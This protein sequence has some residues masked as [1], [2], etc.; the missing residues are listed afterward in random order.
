MTTQHTNLQRY[1]ALMTVVAMIFM[2]IPMVAQAERLTSEGLVCEECG[3][4]VAHKSTCSKNIAP[5]QEYAP[6]ADGYAE[7]SG[8][9]E[10]GTITTDVLLTGDTYLTSI[11]EIP[12]G[13]KVTIDL[14]GYMLHGT[15]TTGVINN[16]GKLTIRDSRPTHGVHKFVPHEDGQWELDDENGTIEITGG[17]IT[18]GYNT[19]TAIGTGGGCIQQGSNHAEDVLTFQS[20]TIVGCYAARAGGAVYGGTINMSGGLVVG[21]Y[22]GQLG[23]A[24]SLSGKLNLS[25]GT[26]TNNHTSPDSEYNDSTKRPFYD[27]ASIIIGGSSAFTMSGGVLVGN[28][29]TV[30]YTL[31]TV[32][33]VMSGGQVLGK[34][35]LLTGA[36]F[37]L[38]N[39]ELNG[40]IYMKSG[41]CIV[42]DTMQ[43]YGG[44]E[45]KGGCICIEGGNF[46]MN[47]GNISVAQG[48]YG[49]AVYVSKG[50]CTIN[51]G[52][53]S[54]CESTYG[55]AVYVTGGEFAMYGGTLTQNT[56]DFGGAIY[57]TGGNVLMNGGSLEYNSANQNGGA[58]YVNAENNNPVI[59]ILSGSITHN[60]ASN[61][62]GAIS[63]NASDASS[64]TVNVGLESCRGQNH[65]EHADGACPTIAN[66]TSGVLGGAL[67]LHSET[68]NIN[69]NVQC[70]S[71][72][73]NKAT[74]NPGSNTLNQGGGHVVVWGGAISPGIM[75]GGG[76]Y[77][78]NRVDEHQIY[79]RFHANYAGGPTEPVLVEVTYGITMVFPV[80]TYIRAGYELSGWAT[81][82]DA[83]GLYIPSN[84]QYAI[85]E[86]ND[87]YLDFYA[88]W[89]ATTSYIVYI[90]DDATIQEDTANITISA[91]LSYFRA[92]SVL[93][94]TMLS[95]FTLTSQYQNHL[96]YHAETN[97]L[98]M[99]RDIESGDV[100]ASFQYNNTNAKTIRLTLDEGQSKYAGL[101]TDTITFVV[102]YEEED[103]GSDALFPAYALLLDNSASATDKYPLVFTRSLS[104]IQVGSTCT[105]PGY[106]QLTVLKV[107]SGFEDVNYNSTGSNPAPWSSDATKITSV[108]VLR[109]IKPLSI[110][111]WFANFQNC[112]YFDIGKI[113]TANAQSFAYTF[114]RAGY[115]TAT[116]TVEGLGRWNTNSLTN[117]VGMFFGS[118]VYAAVYELP[119]IENWNMSSVTS[120]EGMFASAGY[121][122]KNPVLNVTGWDVTSCTTINSMF[123]WFGQ[124]A[125]EGVTIIGLETWDV[126]NIKNMGQA[127]YAIGQQYKPEFIIDLSSWNPVATT[128]WSKIAEGTGGTIIL[129]DKFK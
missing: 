87:G 101:Y 118:G 125:T 58:I 90:P 123:A 99:F 82:P 62:G 73:N 80:D 10:G 15:G 28:V 18:G 69:V 61:H 83:S 96:T 84:G 35:R 55:G 77:D 116:F 6:L 3:Q 127:F 93:S 45:E 71:I 7:W 37:T 107:Y 5:I 113:N 121:R 43:I 20:G 89:N 129:P 67:C 88:V 122:A 31:D 1:I 53:I 81:A 95:D 56:A 30:D 25:G 102:G 59:N 9:V 42:S 66:N 4:N 39:G 36:T 24:F 38:S 17:L 76:I 13:A 57:V 94:V 22:A 47:G 78:D 29:S 51:G 34:F 63:A 117:T 111:G 115:N 46:T 26:I 12:D 103:D 92:N 21:N 11:I 128:N 2:M 50:N 27:D 49:G 110:A 124:S 86:T 65:E 98:G 105:V 120:M 8:T 48:V 32:S 64:I 108:H 52:T 119:G 106:G 75:V 60:D 126:S 19:Q 74:K 97:N 109:T 44:T 16:S 112:S 104:E 72:I 85:T 54:G 114:A 68:Q 91:D 14:N 79:I 70:G 100:V 33:F 23:G 40:S 41:E